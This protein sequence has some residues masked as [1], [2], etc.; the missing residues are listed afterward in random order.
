M[1][2]PTLRCGMDGEC[3]AYLQRVLNAYRPVK[4]AITVDGTFGSETKAAVRLFQM[5]Y[6]LEPDGVVGRYTWAELMR[7]G[8]DNGVGRIPQMEDHLHDVGNSPMPYFLGDTDWIHEWEGHVGKA[9]WPGGKSGVTLDPGFDLAMVEPHLVEEVWKPRLTEAQYDACVAAR[10]YKGKRAKD[11]LFCA[12]A[13]SLR[14]I[15]VSRSEAK[16]IFPF[17][18]APYWEAVVARF[19]DLLTKE[20]QSSV[21]IELRSACQTAFLS[22]GFNRGPGNPALSILKEPLRD[23]RFSVVGNLIASMQQD[24]ELEG[25][26]RRRRAEGHLILDLL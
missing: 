15:R 16:D 18:L 20:G 1:N 23:G 12:E 10:P 21:E 5:T 14:S 2:C 6:G 25:I 8:F 4:S 13:A 19:P 7:H 22:L 24:H 3:V 11:Y 9:Y 26:R 17:I